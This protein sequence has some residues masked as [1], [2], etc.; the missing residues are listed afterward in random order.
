MADR[1]TH[2]IRL[3][4][5]T[6][7]PVPNLGNTWGEHIAAFIVREIEGVVEAQCVEDWT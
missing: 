5:V 4:V 7:G 2:D 3:K 6:E 1:V